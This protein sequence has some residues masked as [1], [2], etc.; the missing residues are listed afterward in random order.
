MNAWF[1]CERRRGNCAASGHSSKGLVT[2][3]RPRVWDRDYASCYCR[4]EQ[5]WRTSPMINACIPSILSRSPIQL[6]VNRTICQAIGCLSTTYAL[7]LLLF[8]PTPA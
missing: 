5:F 1:H 7:A 2:F 6:E 8:L 4:Q 3:D